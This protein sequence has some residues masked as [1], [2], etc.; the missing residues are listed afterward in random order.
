MENYL[1]FDAGAIERVHV[2]RR[3]Y[4]MHLSTSH[5]LFLYI[6][7]VVGFLKCTTRPKNVTCHL[8]LNGRKK[9]SLNWI[10]LET[11][12]EH[13]CLWCRF[14]SC[15][16]YYQPIHQ[17]LGDNQ[18][19]QTC[20]IFRQSE[21][22]VGIPKRGTCALNFAHANGQNVLRDPYNIIKYK[23]LV[24]AYVYNFRAMILICVVGNGHVPLDFKVR[25]GPNRAFIVHILE[26]MMENVL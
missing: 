15:Y 13:Q 18:P 23:C 9:P 2:L 11:P 7:T 10:H 19:T 8:P 5:P 16:Y 25:I 20:L 21:W 3:Y 22:R 4:K 14:I 6:K 1:R 24:Y 17:I 26:K 12:A